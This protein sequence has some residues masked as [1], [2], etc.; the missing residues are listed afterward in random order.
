M[1]T[2]N[3]HQAPRSLVASLSA[4]AAESCAPNGPSEACEPGTTKAL[5]LA[6]LARPRYRAGD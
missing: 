5:V 6:L 4:F 1:G 2:G 3:Q